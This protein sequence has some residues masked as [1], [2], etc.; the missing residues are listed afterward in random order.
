[1][2][3]LFLEGVALLFLL[4]LSLRLLDDTN[5]NSYIERYCLFAM[6]LHIEGGVSD[7]FPFFSRLPGLGKAAHGK[8]VALAT[9]PK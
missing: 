8:I 6:R 3:N 7:L 2:T 4:I 9:Q 5:K 1:M